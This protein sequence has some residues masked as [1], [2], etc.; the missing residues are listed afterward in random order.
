MSSYPR[1][2][3]SVFFQIEAHSKAEVITKKF[4]IKDKIQNCEMKITRN[5]KFQYTQILVKLKSAH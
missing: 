3:K 2:S 4:S 5:S 1:R